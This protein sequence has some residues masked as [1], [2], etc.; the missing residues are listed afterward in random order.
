MPK[1]GCSSL[2]RS[3]ENGLKTIWLN[4][5]EGPVATSKVAAALGVS[6][7]SVSGML[8]KLTEL[9]SV[10]HTRYRGAKLIPRG[11]QAALKLLRRRARGRLES[12]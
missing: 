7:A 2:S 12:L 9:G 1:P 4:D 6:N 11:E 8:V 10:N 3:V 5:H